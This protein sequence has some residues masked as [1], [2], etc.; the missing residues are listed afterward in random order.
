MGASIARGFWTRH[1]EALD[2]E[3]AM[4]KYWQI[5]RERG[6]RGIVEIVAERP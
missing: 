4:I 2:G 1:S 5:R 3:Q 6:Q